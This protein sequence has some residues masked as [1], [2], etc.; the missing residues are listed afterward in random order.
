MVNSTASIFQNDV[1]ILARRVDFDRHSYS[2]E[3]GA[4]IS[5][6]EIFELLSGRVGFDSQVD[7]LVSKLS[8]G[9]SNVTNRI[10]LSNFRVAAVTKLRRV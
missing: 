10:Q 8:I 3:T 4:A 5:G 7:A 1:N 9:K 2:R 6:S